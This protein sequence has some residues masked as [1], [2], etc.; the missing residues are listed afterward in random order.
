[1]A[2]IFNKSR[3]SRFVAKSSTDFKTKKTSK[4]A[5]FDEKSFFKEVN[6]Q[7]DFDLEDSRKA[8]VPAKTSHSENSPFLMRSDEANEP[9][10]AYRDGITDRQLMLNQMA[11]T[12]KK[13]TDS[14]RNDLLKRYER[15]SALSYYNCKNIFRICEN[16]H[17]ES[18]EHLEKEFQSELKQLQHKSKWRK[19]KELKVLHQ[20]RN[21]LHSIRSGGCSPEDET[22]AQS[23]EK[24][25]SSF[26]Y[27]GYNNRT[28]VKDEFCYDDTGPVK[29]NFPDQLRR[30]QDERMPSSQF[31]KELET[32]VQ[33]KM[34]SYTF[35]LAN[36]PEPPMLTQD[37]SYHLVSSSEPDEGDCF[38]SPSLTIAASLELPD[39]S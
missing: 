16:R 34:D 14:A 36:S 12:T 37:N 10:Q 5:V 3:R 15:H 18:T 22:F 24:A 27:P 6:T 29:I 20:L 32:A 4:C 19:L 8:K 21:N 11:N 39:L 30:S 13:G 1:M 7:E 26:E 38:Q 28:K 9:D 2:G 17:L 35:H 23:T 33:A 25:L 31:R